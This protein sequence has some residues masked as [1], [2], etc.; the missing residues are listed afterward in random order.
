MLS[1]AICIALRSSRGCRIAY[2]TRRFSHRAQATEGSFRVFPPLTGMAG[3]VL[4]KA[5]SRIVDDS[6]IDVERQVVAALR[7]Y[8]GN[9]LAG[10]RPL[11]GDGRD[12]G[13][14]KWIDASTGGSWPLIDLCEP[15]TPRMSRGRDRQRA[16]H[17]CQTTCSKPVSQPISSLRTGMPVRC[18]VGLPEKG[19]FS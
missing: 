5:T 6:C 18:Y 11:R 7:Q 13:H 15:H 10:N 16:T 2:R 9:L 19:P 12:L 4:V 17:S 8:H 1:A 14:A 3:L